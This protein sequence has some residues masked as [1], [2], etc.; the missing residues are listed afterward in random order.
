MTCGLNPV[1]Y[2]TEALG[3]FWFYIQVGF[4]IVVGLVALW[5]LA[6][7]HQIAGWRGVA[8]VL[9]LGAA[10]LVFKAGRDS[11]KR[12]E[13]FDPPARSVKPKPILPKGDDWLKRIFNGRNQ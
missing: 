13:D 9:T 10:G 3:P 7:V 6:K 11:V 8:A 4:W 12:E 5:A 1:C 2:V